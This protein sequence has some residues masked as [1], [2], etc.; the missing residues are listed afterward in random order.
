M[1]EAVLEWIAHALGQGFVGAMLL[2]ALWWVS[3]LWPGYGFWL[4]GKLRWLAGKYEDAA[5]HG[6]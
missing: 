3:Y 2:L 1:T 6:D 4:A 5:H